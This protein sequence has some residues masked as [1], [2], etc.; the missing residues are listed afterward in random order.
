MTYRTSSLLAGLLSFGLVPVSQAASPDLPVYEKVIAPLLQSRCVECHGEERTKGKLRMDSYD[1]LLKGGSEGPSLVPGSLE[2]S[3][4]IYRITLP[5]DDEYDEHMPPADKEQLTAGQ[6]E[7]LKHWVKKGA[8]PAMTLADLGA[9][10]D[11]NETIDAILAAASE[12]PA[13]K[14]EEV[15]K[16]QLTDAQKKLAQKVM[17]EVNATGASLMPIAQDTPMLRFTALNVADRF[18]DGELAALE[19]VADQ[20]MWLDLG[21]TKVT[22]SGLATVAKMPHLEKLHLEGTKVTDAGLK[23]LSGLTELRYLNLYKTSVG[24]AGLKHL[25]SLGN[26]DRLYLWQSEVTAEGAEKLRQSLPNLNINLGWDYES[27]K[28]AV[29]VVAAATTQ[30]EKKTEPAEKPAKKQEEKKP[31]Q[32]KPAEVSAEKKEQKKPAKKVAEAA[33]KGEKPGELSGVAARL[34]EAHKEA[35]VLVEAKRQAAASANRHLNELK[36]QCKECCDQIPAA[37]ARVEKA[38]AHVA[39]LDAVVIAIR[40][41]LTAVSPH[42]SLAALKKSLTQDLEEARKRHEA[43]EKDLASKEATVK[44]LQQS[45]KQFKTKMGYAE[46]KLKLAQAGVRDHQAVADA[47]AQALKLASK[48]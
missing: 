25:A 11:L 36:S 26:L 9:P 38:A 44:E 16:H 39:S 18:G 29:Q 17:K 3:L 34:K 2:D 6:I 27:K 12:E 10:Q 19:P 40:E 21:R 32:K 41:A 24:N 46:K 5:I 47:I 4:M 14:K 33:S 1:A 42:D 8:D 31:E 28:E 7:L 23:H 13:K 20:I 30:P 45:D 22:D 37:K 35:L 15:A 43:A 48:S